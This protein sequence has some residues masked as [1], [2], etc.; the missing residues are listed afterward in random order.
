MI[1]LPTPAILDWEVAEGCFVGG[2]QVL[3]LRLRRME[4]VGVMGEREGLGGERREMGWLGEESVMLIGKSW[5]SG[6]LPLDISDFQRFPVSH[7]P[8]KYHRCRK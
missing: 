8:P 3:S 1:A 2:M 5:G 6:P 7:R 4:P